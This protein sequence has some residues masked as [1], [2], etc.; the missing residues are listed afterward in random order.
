MA[1]AAAPLPA[2]GCQVALAARG[3]SS[4]AMGEG[5]GIKPVH[6]IPAFML[7]CFGSPARMRKWGCLETM[8]ICEDQGHTGSNQWFL[9]WPFDF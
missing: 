4:S 2:R 8:D 9:V 7:M 5:W 3:W 6:I 1:E